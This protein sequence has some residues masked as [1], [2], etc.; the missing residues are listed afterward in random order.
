MLYTGLFQR[1]SSGQPLTEDGDILSCTYFNIPSEPQAVGGLLPH[2]L[3][4]PAAPAPS[5]FLAG[6]AIL[7]YFETPR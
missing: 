5:V 3:A 4:R 2:P 7:G 1:G 6:F